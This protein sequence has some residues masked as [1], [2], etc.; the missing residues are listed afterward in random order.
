MLSNHPHTAVFHGSAIQNN[1]QPN[2]AERYLSVCAQLKC[3]A[4]KLGV[5]RYLKDK[6]QWTWDTLVQHH[7]RPRLL[8]VRGKKMTRVFLFM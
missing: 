3:Q 7:I 8:N 4:S 1:A 2:T 6:V 5:P